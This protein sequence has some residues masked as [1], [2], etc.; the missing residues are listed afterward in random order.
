M[1]YNYPKID[2]KILE[3]EILS[4][5]NQDG[6]LSLKDLPNPSLLKDMNRAT[7]RIVKAINNKEKIILIG[8][9]D[10]DGVVSTT[11]VK[12]FFNDI[13]IK[14]DWIIPNRFKDGYGLSP[15]L[16]PKIEGYDL[17]IT[18]DNGISAITASKMC[19]EKNIDL[20]ITDHHLLASE[21][22]DAYA[23][24]D[25]KQE[26]CDFPYSEI[27]GA[28]IAWYLIASLKNA[29]N[30]KIDIKYY[31]E[32][33]SIAI[34]ADMM[35]LKHI[36]RAMVTF[37]IKLINQSDRPCLLAFKEHINKNILESDDIGFN[38]A[39]ILN[40]SGRMDDASYSVDFLMSKNISE[41]RDKLKILIDFNN[42]R[43]EIEQQITNE[44]ISLVDKNDSVLVLAGDD[45][46]EGVL[47]IISARVSRQYSKPSII[48]T[49]SENGDLK[50]SGRSFGD[51]NLF[52]ITNECRDYL[53][54]FGGHHSAIGLS[55]DYNNLDDFKNQLQEEYRKKDYQKSLFDPEIIGEL[56]FKDIN[57]N[58]INMMKKYEPY[59]QEN[60]RPKFITK[61]IN[62]LK[63]DT[64]G[65]SKEH[66][67]FAF[68]KDGLILT[69]VKFKTTEKFL[70]NQKVSISYTINE[71][72]FM[73]KTN[74][75]LMIDKILI[76]I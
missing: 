60:I 55:L 15:T 76:I 2:K 27:C 44:A 50:G 45:W 14:L 17:A 75:Q 65:K 47:G 67:R 22:P 58:L 4:R 8:D 33:V 29:L 62:I 18:V 41:A 63:V 56:E 28:Q 57:F 46:H 30:V 20:I 59:G 21:T 66:L 16:M 11:L 13:G 73:G 34:I 26:D 69:G 40:S 48:L 52:E 74:I 35:P 39:P 61:N 19:K 37:G 64:M 49:K 32:L 42:K 7:D 36:N 24:I 6:F 23:I 10:V 54:K 5:F 25:Q 9:Y 72:N 70:N 12:T 71:N 53:N 1:N 31:L 43:K 38:I 51:C 3:E 68:E